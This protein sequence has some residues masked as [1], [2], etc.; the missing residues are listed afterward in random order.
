MEIPKGAKGLNSNQRQITQVSQFQRKRSF[1]IDKI[2][3][4]YK[5]VHKW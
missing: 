4:N 5:E 3:Q 1:C 2:E